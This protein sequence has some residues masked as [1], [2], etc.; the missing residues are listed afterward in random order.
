MQQYDTSHYPPAFGYSQGYPYAGPQ[1]G[2]PRPAYYPDA[3]GYPT[4]AAS[5]RAASSSRRRS[6]TQAHEYAGAEYARAAPPRRAATGYA[7]FD[8]H[9]QP[10]PRRAQTYTPVTTPPPPHAGHMPNIYAFGA[11]AHAEYDARRAYAPSYT[12]APAPQSPPPAHDG[13]RPRAHRREST[14]SGGD[15]IGR[16]SCRERV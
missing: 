2:A 4:P 1:P 15:E 3:T 13:R 16:A 14:W 11:H 7:E 10:S 8:A 5:P 12:P 9:R 6:N